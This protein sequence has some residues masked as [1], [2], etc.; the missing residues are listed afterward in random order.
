VRGDQIPLEAF[1]LTKVEVL[2][3]GPKAAYNSWKP[4]TR[5]ELA[6]LSA[7]LTTLTLNSYKLVIDLSL[8]HSPHVLPNLKTLTL[9]KVDLHVPLQ[10]CL[11]FP[12][13][14]SLTLSRVYCRPIGKDGQEIREDW[15]ERAA[16]LLLNA[17]FFQT[18]PELE[19][20]CL[21]YSSIDDHLVIALQV[22]SKL[23]NLTIAAY[24]FS[25]TELAIIG[26]LLEESFSPNLNSFN[27]GFGSWDKGR[28]AYTEFVEQCLTRRPKLA[29]FT[30]EYE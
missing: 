16:K 5:F 11:K 27:I 30:H 15:E 14:Q 25:E 20:L 28:M 10:E 18:I 8:P 4:S 22:C 26:R 9:H 3:I 12:K 21:E 29:L 19:I 24:S 23:A 6:S 2:D 1:G 17:S 7:G 13:L